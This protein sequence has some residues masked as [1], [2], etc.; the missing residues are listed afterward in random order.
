M[1]EFWFQNVSQNPPKIQKLEAPSPCWG[2]LWESNFALG[3]KIL[4]GVTSG[5]QICSK[6]GR[7][8]LENDLKE[9]FY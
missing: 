8:V 5:H 6:L 4:P 2:R 9:V 3:S 1:L 7:I